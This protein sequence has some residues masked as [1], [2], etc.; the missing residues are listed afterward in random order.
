MSKQNI[1]KLYNDYM[2]VVVEYR[3]LAWAAFV[4]NLRWTSPHSQ[5]YDILS[6]AMSYPQFLEIHNCYDIY[7][8]KHIIDGYNTANESIMKAKLEQNLDF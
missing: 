5:D 7:E 1:E 8:L 3:E 6:E 2:K 4:D